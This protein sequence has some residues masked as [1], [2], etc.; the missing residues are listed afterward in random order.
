MSIVTLL[1]T[2]TDAALA[3]RIRS[4]LSA[5]GVQIGETVQAGREAVTVAVLSPKALEDSGFQQNVVKALE[6]N[7]HIIPVLAAKV[8]LPRLLNNL[9][10]VDFSERYDAKTLLERVNMLSAPDAPPPMAILTPTR[11]DANRRVGY[12]IGGIVIAFFVVGIWAVGSGT[13]QAPADEFAS[14]ETQIILTR[15]YFIDEALP[16][17]T[18]DAVNFPATVENI[19]TK[20]LME[21]IA[22][23]TAIA[24][25]VDGTFIPRSS[26]EATNFPATLENVSTVVHDRLLATVTAA[27]NGQ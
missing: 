20:A 13:V 14:V 10:A 16:R 19:P 9:Q 8:G 1:N 23:A 26:E 6:N 21:L 24:G 12:L 3:G 5:A 4:D 15:N 25:G 2:P 27:A 18:E 22:T 7:Q 17:S 11:R